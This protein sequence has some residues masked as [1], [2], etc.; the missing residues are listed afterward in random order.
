MNKLCC[1]LLISCWL[2]FNSSCQKHPAP[3]RQK[4]SSIEK[5]EDANSS[6]QEKKT[7]TPDAA[8]ELK[9]QGISPYDLACHNHKNGDVN[10]HLNHRVNSDDSDD[11]DD[12]DDSDDSDKKFLTYN[13]YEIVK[14]KEKGWGDFERKR[15][16]IAVLAIKK[17]GR[18]IKKF[19]GL[20]CGFQSSIEAEM[21]SPLGQDSCLLLIYTNCPR[22][23]QYWI[24]SLDSEVKILFD[25]ADYNVGGEIEELRFFDPDND[26]V[27]EFC[28]QFNSFRFF[29]YLD[30]VRSP[31][32]KFYFKYDKNSGKYLPA[33]PL[34]KDQPPLNYADINLNDYNSSEDPE[35]Y[36]S[37]RLYFLLEYIFVGEEEKGWRFFDATY[38]QPDKERIKAA[39]KKILRKEPI[40]KYLYPTRK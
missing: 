36:L 26:G 39:V 40:Y 12:S 20:Y 16:D 21:I 25:S 9:S 4:I 17:D 33:R 2:F 24:V 27:K 5:Q 37:P 38:H 10:G 23:G 1:L 29:E 8:A 6:H 34:I 7:N 14:Q 11:N 18:V 28:L 31:V 3:T 30:N 32:F 35:Y 19:R 15:V 22:S 13:G